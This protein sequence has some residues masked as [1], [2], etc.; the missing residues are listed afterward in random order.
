MASRRAAGKRSDIIHSITTPLGF[1]VL[2]L[3]IVEATLAV[4]LSNAKLT[5][6]HIW[7]GFLWMIGIFI[8]VVFVVTLLTVFSPKN[9][10]YG[11]EEHSQAALSPSALRDQIEDL[12][13]AHVREECL[14]PPA[15]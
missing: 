11:K 14:K 8:G 6:P 3:L 5:E 12:I 4:V 7:A 9:L 15:H 1:F 10:L 13:V 2:A